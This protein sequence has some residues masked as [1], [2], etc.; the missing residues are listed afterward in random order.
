MRLIVAGLVSGIK[1]TN[2]TTA[3][4][5]TPSA[6]TILEGT[7]FSLASRHTPDSNTFA[8]AIASLDGWQEVNCDTKAT[9][10]KRIDPYHCAQN[11]FMIRATH[12]EIVCNIYF[13]AQ[14]IMR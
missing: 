1:Q 6:F 10:L 12:N 9:V 4:H 7:C 13:H 14:H 11:L 5:S 2:A 3:I 8:L